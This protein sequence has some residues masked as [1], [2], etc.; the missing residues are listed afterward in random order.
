MKLIKR[1]DSTRVKLERVWIAYNKIPMYTSAY[2]KQLI[3]DETYT[4]ISSLQAQLKDELNQKRLWNECA[5]S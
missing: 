2:Y 5:K 3:L 1:C 4:K